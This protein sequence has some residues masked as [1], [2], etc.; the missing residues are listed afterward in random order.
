MDLQYL[1][2]ERKDRRGQKE[3]NLMSKCTK[4]PQMVTY[5][6]TTVLY[7][8]G[9][10][11]VCFS[12]IVH[13]FIIEAFWIAGLYAWMANIISLCAYSVADPEICPRGAQ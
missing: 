5:H 2:K 10:H 4:K 3:N 13:N 7:T 8:T 12:F 9:F 1:L 6:T 11:S